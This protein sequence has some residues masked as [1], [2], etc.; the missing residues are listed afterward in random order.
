[1]EFM[2]D[3]IVERQLTFFESESLLS[4][5]DIQPIRWLLFVVLS[6]CHSDRRILLFT[7]SGESS[8]QRY[9]ESIRQSLTL[10]SP[11]IDTIHCQL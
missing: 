3:Q 7:S 5:N 10:K 11:K 2:M 4:P 6:S 9:T 1:M 8:L